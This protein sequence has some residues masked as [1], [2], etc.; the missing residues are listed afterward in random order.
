MAVSGGELVISLLLGVESLGL[1]QIAPLAICADWN[2]S[3]D[4]DEPSCRR[5]AVCAFL[6][7]SLSVWLGELFLDDRWLVAILPGP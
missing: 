5:A 7:Q 6:E 2:S 3:A 1:Y 4:D